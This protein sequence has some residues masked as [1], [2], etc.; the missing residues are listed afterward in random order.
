MSILTGTVLG[1]YELVRKVGR[2]GMSS[3]YK[4]I[5]I[6]N[7]RVV[8]VKVLP[9][10]L[11]EEE[12]FRARFQREAKVLMGLR[13]PNIVPMLDFGE[14]D[15]MYY[16]VM[17][18][19]NVGTLRGRLM[20][21]PLRPEDGARIIEQ[22]AAALQYAH[23]C[24]IIHRDVK[25][26][27]I[28]LD[29]KGNAWLSDFGTAYVR[30][31][32]AQ[33]TGSGLIGTP[34]YMAPEQARGDPVSPLTDEYSLAVVLYQMSTG[35]LPYDA[36]TP[37][38]IAMK[39][40]T[41]PLPLPRMVN[42]NLPE[43]IEAVLVKAL[44]KN[45][46]DR[47]DSVQDFNWAFQQALQN[48]YDASSGQLKPG[49]RQPAPATLH[50]K[51]VPEKL[52]ESKDE[53][54]REGRGRWIALALLTLMIGVLAILAATGVFNTSDSSLIEQQRAT[55]DALSTSVA[56]GLDEGLSQ[57]QLDTAVAATLGAQG[58]FDI[59]PG[60]GSPTAEGTTAGGPAP[61]ETQSPGE[62]TAPAASET[63]M[64]LIV[65]SSTSTAT[66][67]QTPSRTPTRTL[68]GTATVTRTPSRTPTPTVSATSTNPPVPTATP[69]NSPTVT[70]TLAPTATQ[71]PCPLINLGNFGT[72]GNIARWTITNNTGSLITL[73]SFSLNWPMD[74]LE[75]VRATLGGST[76]WTGSDYSGSTS[77]TTS[78]SISTS[79]NIEF[80]FGM[81]AASTGYSINV[82]FSNGCS[83][84]RSQ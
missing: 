74:N 39:H 5:D 4:A 72:P 84:Q 45:P 68:A 50:L 82:G 37:L 24:G 56:A 34:H 14:A 53:P 32:T 78:R 54:A 20:G 42:E 75:L 9:P 80:E 59:I 35:Q 62:G 12:S 43:A 65:L 81:P 44:S 60:D 27:N 28:L 49:A 47:Y 17:P 58:A 63:D 64:S 77:G 48:V 25:P 33:L 52:P 61:G 57:A 36:D 16:L 18:F 70:R 10:G 13:H 11:A 66:R 73:T 8:A 6:T 51:P 7:E 29:E 2:G 55:I 23:D 40:T 15:D 31:A 41:E 83:N 71:D 26:S 22:M 3:V 21:G 76:I 1:R 69:T 30:E 79:A 19:M 46:T 67:T 38:A